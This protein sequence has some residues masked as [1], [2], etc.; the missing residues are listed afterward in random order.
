[1]WRD[2]LPLHLVHKAHGLLP[3]PRCTA[4]DNCRLG[5][6]V[7]TTKTSRG[8]G[9]GGGELGLRVLT[10]VA[11]TWRILRGKHAS[12]TLKRGPR[13]AVVP[14]HFTT[15]APNSALTS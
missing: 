6:G 12:H 13:T 5:H 8:D 3:L 15:V 4:S 11:A 7:E 14:L 9:R 10:Y 1:M 2:S